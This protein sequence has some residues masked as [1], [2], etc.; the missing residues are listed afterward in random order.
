MFGAVAATEFEV[1]SDREVTVTVPTGAT[2]G[3]IKITT[4][5]GATTSKKNFTVTK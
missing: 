5:G 1:V 3:A 4:S 2:T